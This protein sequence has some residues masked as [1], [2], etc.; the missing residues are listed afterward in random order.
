[1]S[2]SNPVR[3]LFAGVFVLG[4]ASAALAAPMTV[5]SSTAPGLSPGDLVKDGDLVSL[6][7][8]AAVQ[9]FTVT[10]KEINL[11]GPYSGPPQDTGNPPAENRLL[12]LAGILL[13]RTEMIVANDMDRSHYRAQPKAT[14]DLLAGGTWCMASDQPAVILRGAAVDATD[15][16]LVALDTGARA[17]MRW[18]A[19]QVET[20]WPA[21]LPPQ[22][23][24]RY[25]VTAGGVTTEFTLRIL[26]DAV[27][28]AARLAQMGEAGCRAQVEKAISLLAG[29]ALSAGEPGGQ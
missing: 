21:A 29:E 26:P 22:D 1:M 20:P 9:L 8:G 17:L 18:D 13:G 5:I 25:S 3:A 24:G 4:A 15:A 7:E 10:G 23:G 2:K 27:N 6:P 19:G 28:G 12:V 14:L 16:Q 11:S